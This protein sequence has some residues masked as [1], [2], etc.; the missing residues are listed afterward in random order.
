VVWIEQS[1]WLQS[2]LQESCVIWQP[3]LVRL[4]LNTSVLA[5][6]QLNSNGDIYNIAQKV[7]NFSLRQGPLSLINEPE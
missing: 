6:I 4:F 5:L 3:S 2:E 7:F 1:A